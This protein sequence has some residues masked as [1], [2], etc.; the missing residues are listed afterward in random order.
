MANATKIRTALPAV[1]IELPTTDAAPDRQQL[2]MQVLDMSA[3]LLKLASVLDF[4]EK[5]GDDDAC[6]AVNLVQ[7]YVER[8]TAHLD[9]MRMAVRA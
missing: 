4:L 5:H 9:D 2:S 6:G 8:L 1:A 7:S 3:D